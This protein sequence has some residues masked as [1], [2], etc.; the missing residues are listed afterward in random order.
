MPYVALKTSLLKDT[1]IMLL[2]NECS[3]FQAETVVI[4]NP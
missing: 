3:F 2:L 4:V 1:L